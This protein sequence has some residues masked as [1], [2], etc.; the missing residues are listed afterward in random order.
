MLSTAKIR[1]DFPIL[2]IKIHGKKLIYLDSAATAQRPACVINAISD[3]YK[4]YNSNIHRGIHKLAEE[5]TLAYERAHEKVARFIDA[6]SKEEIVFTRNATE[7][8][9]L[10]AHTIARKRLLLGDEILLTQ[11]EHH[12]NL[13]PWQQVA[14]ET[15]AKLKFVKITKD[16]RLDVDDFKRQLSDKVKFV[17]IS[18]VSNVLG[19][20]NPVEELTKLAHGVGALVLVDAAQ[21][22]PHMAVDVKK[23]DADF[24]AFS[25]HKMLGP[26]GIGVLYGKKALLEQ[27]E[28]LLFGGD[29]VSEVRFDS[30]K[31]NELPWKF[32]AGTPNIAG[33]I[34]LAAAID[35]L[36]RLGIANVAKHTKELTN[37]ALTKLRKVG[38]VDI[39]GPKNRM[40][41]ISFNVKGIHPHDLATLLDREGIA[42]RAGH[43]CAMPLHGVLGIPASARVSFYLYNT[44]E[45]VDKFIKTLLKVKKF[46]GVG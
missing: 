42:I 15:G 12:A 5:S 13:V 8:I 3:Y 20:V 22:V 31:W 19:T 30:A 39:Y 9:N 24:V 34:G 21:S 32:E 38:N 41:V 26:T 27:M 6:E 7:A 37:Y 23:I 16:G 10:V 14:K 25:G 46:F 33:A 35:Y 18:H 36:E 4:T 11:M 2:K 1:K 17:S 29:M 45:D 43:H 44:K 40:G 28:P